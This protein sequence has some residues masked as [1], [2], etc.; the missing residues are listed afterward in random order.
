M[1]DKHVLL[2]TSFAKRLART[3]ENISEQF[4]VVSEELFQDCVTWSRIIALYALAGRLALYYRENNM[5]KLAESIP[6][7]MAH[8]IAGKIASFV[9]KNG[10]W[11]QLC[12]EFPPKKD[13]SV[14]VWRSL[15][16][17]GAALGIVAALLMVHS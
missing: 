1:L 5:Q 15:L 13:L 9:I 12:V 17:T 3:P 2:F 4:L 6:Q 14:K 7:C 10:G 8:C 11:E 16:V